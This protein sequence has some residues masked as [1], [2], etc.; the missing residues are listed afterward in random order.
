MHIL[1]LN[2]TINWVYRLYEEYILSIINSINLNYQ[3]ITVE[4]IFIDVNSENMNNDLDNILLKINNYDKIFLSGDISTSNKFFNNY[5][6]QKDNHIKKNNIF[7]LDDDSISETSK[8]IQ[9]IYNYGLL[10]RLPAGLV[11][12]AELQADGSCE[13]LQNKIDNDKDN[14]INNKIYDDIEFYF[15]N[16]EQ[17]SNENYFKNLIKLDNKINI[18]D[19]SEEN[20]PYFKNI[21]NKI[22]LIPPY[23]QYKS[24]I[25][26][27][28]KKIDII[29]FINNEYRK[30]YVNN[31]NLNDKYKIILLDNCFGE[32]RNKYFE[33][34]K[35]YINFH[36]SDQHK[37]MEL[38]RIVNLIMNKVIVITQKSIY[39]D[40]LYLKDY[41]IECNDITN[42]NTYITEI[43]DNYELY[44]H[45]FFDNFDENK[46]L[47]YIK[48][49]IDGL[50]F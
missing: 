48:K 45:K 22:Y 42:F 26:C 2:I 28:Y 12:N 38:I 14:K 39:S 4:N 37:T 15:I 18:I 46:Y 50:L 24:H 21:Y 31:L 7:I 9:K 40:L 16:I 44:F 6:Y 13:R 11:S 17:M 8:Y 32:N 41:I 23:F 30:E 3:N 43:L 47:K 29:S 5:Q 1:I 34:S 49:N 36:C 19:Y 27:N 25:S 10:Q 20:I 33:K 35:I